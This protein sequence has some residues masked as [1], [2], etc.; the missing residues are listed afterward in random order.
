[1]QPLVEER[2]RG[3][4]LNRTKEPFMRKL[5]FFLLSFFFLVLFIAVNGCVISPRRIVGG[6]TGSGSNSEFSLTASPTTQSVTAGASVVFTVTVQALNSFTGTV[7][8][9]VS[10]SSSNVTA[11]LD[12]PTIPGG[13]GAAN[14]TVQTGTATPTGNA[15]LTV[16]GTDTANN[17]SQSV[18]VTVSVT[19][20]TASATVP[21]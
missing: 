21:A 17:V 1:M 15:T 8:L 2:N 4:L 14:L 5:F 12:N 10:S 20:S 9:T 19:S 16:T 7:S 11:S 3:E 6:S 18:T 13:T